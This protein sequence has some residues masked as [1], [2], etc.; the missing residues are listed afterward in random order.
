MPT[1]THR[2][3]DGTEKQLTAGNKPL[4]IGR[5]A[6]SDIPIRDSFLSRVHC[7]IAYY[8]Q[9]FHLKDLGSTNGTY[10]NGA[11]VFECPLTAGDR[12]QIGN[13]TLLFE[14]AAADHGIL[15]MY[16]A[17]TGASRE[18]SKVTDPLNIPQP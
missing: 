8:N 18:A 16:A 6:D 11:R 10:R 12:I 2:Q 15:S 4:V 7:G 5:L 13:T 14:L 1:L 9:Q 17:A 3:P